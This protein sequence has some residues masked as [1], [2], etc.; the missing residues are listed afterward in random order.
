MNKHPYLVRLQQIIH[1][2]PDLS[3]PQ[4]AAH[5]VRL[6]LARRIALALDPEGVTCDELSD[7][8]VGSARTQQ[9]LHRIKDLG[10]NTVFSAEALAGH[11]I[12]MLVDRGHITH[13]QSLSYMRG[14]EDPTDQIELFLKDNDF[15]RVPAAEGTTYYLSTR[16]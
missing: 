11:A 2:L 15:V 5:L 9:S 3:E 8:A 12:D 1:D 16:F 4:S 7:P 14:E 6:D 13:E 10:Y